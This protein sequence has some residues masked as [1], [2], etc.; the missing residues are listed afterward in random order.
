MG[1]DK[2]TL[3]I[4]LLPLNCSSS[5]IFEKQTMNPTK[6]ISSKN[7]QTRKHQLFFESESTTFNIRNLKSPTHT[8]TELSTSN[9]T[10]FRFLSLNNKKVSKIL[11]YNIFFFSFSKPHEFEFQQKPSNSN[12]KNHNQL[13]IITIKHQHKNKVR[14]KNLDLPVSVY[15]CECVYVSSEI[16]QWK[17]ITQRTWNNNLAIISNL[18]EWRICKIVL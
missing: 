10:H 2:N 6:K 11:K 16:L 12:S 13:Q 7:N 9:I 1:M 3:I 15:K 8:Q 14:G 4:L 5:S 18:I 17:K